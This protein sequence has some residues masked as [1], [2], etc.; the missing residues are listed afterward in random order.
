MPVYPRGGG[1][2]ICRAFQAAGYDGLSPRGRGN[3]KKKTPHTDSPRSIPAGAGGTHLHRPLNTLATRVYPRGGGGTLF[4]L[5]P[6]APGEGL[7]PR[8]RGNHARHY[9]RCGSEGSIP[10]GAGEPFATL[11]SPCLSPVYPRGGGGTQIWLALET[12]GVG[13]SP[14]G[15]GNQQP[16]GGLSPRGR[17]NQRA[18]ERQRVYPRGGGGTTMSGGGGSRAEGLSPRGRGNLQRPYAPD[19]VRGSIPAGAGEPRRHRVQLGWPRGL[20][21]R[22]RGNPRNRH[23]LPLIG[24]R[25]IPAGAGE[26]I[27]R[28][29]QQSPGQV[30]PRGGGGTPPLCLRTLGLSPRGRGNRLRL[31]VYP[32]G[33]GGTR[34]TF[35]DAVYPRG[36]GGILLRT[37][38]LSP[39]GRGNPIDVEILAPVERSIPAGAGEPCRQRGRRG[40][41]VVYPRGGGGTVGRLYLIRTSG[42]LSP[43]GRGN[44]TRRIPR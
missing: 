30:Y 13:L 19:S 41:P 23:R 3:P 39:R 1:G 44:P 12:D 40:R 15:R 33:G 28:I 2:T 32:R 42:G 4:G 6:E 29:C 31:A 20:S 10:A 17:G 11:L 24:K 21:P 8:G 26:P 16:G 5:G 18:G 25:S 35:I 7:S 14:R 22:G 34:T 36:G 43:R 9:E 38:G 27:H 37:E